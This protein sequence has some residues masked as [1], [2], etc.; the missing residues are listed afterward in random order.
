MTFTMLLKFLRTVSVNSESLK[1]GWIPKRAFNVSVSS[2]PSAVLI[3]A[4]NPVDKNVLM[5][6]L[7]PFV[8]SYLSTELFNIVMVLASSSPSSRSRPDP[9]SE[10]GQSEA[11]GSTSGPCR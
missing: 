10:H 5:L 8:G 6:L 3:L 1:A 4:Q 9:S 7:S 2:R 11:L